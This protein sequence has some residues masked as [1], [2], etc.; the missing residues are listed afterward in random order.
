MIT[1][2]PNENNNVNGLGLINNTV[3]KGNDILIKIIPIIKRI[4][5]L[6]H[7]TIDPF[8]DDNPYYSSS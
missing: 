3:A 4:P 2:E 1:N 8:I 5:N 6:P 7:S